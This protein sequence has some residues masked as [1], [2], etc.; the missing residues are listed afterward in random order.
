MKIYI[1]DFV[2]HV[3]TRLT[4]TPSPESAFAEEREGLSLRT[5]IIAHAEGSVAAAIMETPREQLDD[6]STFGRDVAF[7]TGGAGYVMLPDDFLRLVSFRMSDWSRSVT[8]AA[9][10][11]SFTAR[12]QTSPWTPLHGRPHRPVCVLRQR[13]VGRVLD[14]YTCRSAE[15]T[16]EE[17]IYIA[18]PRIS[19]TG[20]IRLP[21][22]S[23]SPA[24]DICAKR[25]REDLDA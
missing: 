22:A 4:E 3:L 16:V 21:S 1:D 12:L 17:G 6:F 11:D 23:L 15:A 8:E 14:F 25:V 9:A 10:E 13:G 19:P 20:Y 24:A 18:R 2:S 5:L 7:T